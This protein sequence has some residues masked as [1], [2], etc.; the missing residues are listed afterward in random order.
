[1]KMDKKLSRRIALVFVL[2]LMGL[3]SV[4]VCTAQPT[5]PSL[6][7]P[8]DG[9]TLPQP[10]DPWTFDWTDSIDLKNGIRQY[11]LYVVHKGAKNPV[12]DDYVKDSH[13][14]KTLGGYITDENLKGWTWK[15]RAQ[16]NK[17]LWSDWSETWT[18]DVEARD[19]TPPTVIDNTPIGENV[20]VRARITI[21]F[22]EPMDKGS[23]KKAFSIYP[24][25]SG[26]F[27]WEE[28]TMVFNPRS[29]L[30]HGTAYTV[31][32]GTEAKDSAD[33]NLEVPYEWSFMTISRANNQPNILRLSGPG[34]G[35][36]GTS[37]SYS[38]S[39]EDP[40]GDDI[41]YTVDWGD[42][43]TSETEFM[44]S[45]ETASLSHDW[46]EPGEYYIRVKATDDKGANS[47]W[48]ESL[49]VVARTPELI[50]PTAIISATP[51]EINEGERVSFSAEASSDQDGYIVSYDWDFGDGN[52]GAGMNVEHTYYHSGHYT[53]TLTVTDND[54]LSAR[55]RV[56]ITA[57]PPASNTPP[58]AYID[59]YPNP[60]G[61][62]ERVTFEGYGEDGD[63]EVVEC[64]WTFSDG[65]TFL[66]SG[67]SSWFTLESEEVQ[68]G[69]YSFAVKDDD[70]AW[71]EEAGLYLE[72][73]IPPG[74]PWVWILAATVLVIAVALFIKVAMK[75][76]PQL[77]INI[78]TGGGVESLHESQLQQYTINVEVRGGIK[79][80]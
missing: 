33:N 37:Y 59:I 14:S 20:P 39:A 72:V 19:T 44:Y 35:Y 45:G 73:G 34:S 78:E 10:G 48:A 27:D 66:D 46:T 23:V 80:L 56:E 63:G 11:E 7:S 26:E 52:T 25:V 49:I 9:A 71:S 61:E 40:D 6:I 53:A 1:M 47:K 77:Q 24:E 30:N 31:M 12:I 69:W 43:T 16:N 79:R 76:P 64:R 62:G 41:K 18:F 68:E 32:I 36:I 28:N 75:E 74:I 17:E 51:V 55:D 13:Y 67:S 50:P 65:R 60:A 2:L 22:S 5:V 8:H 57:N 15:V 42:G 54:A 70:G 38:T 21:T 58:M 29:N 3:F 4:S